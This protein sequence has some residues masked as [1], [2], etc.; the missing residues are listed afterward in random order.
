M[1]KLLLFIV[2]GLFYLT[3]NS[4]NYVPFPTDS[5]KWNCLLHAWGV[6]GQEYFINYRYTMDGD[7]LILG[8]QYKKIYFKDLED[9]INPR[10]Y[11]GGLRED[12][13]QQI[14]FFPYN[15]FLPSYT[16]YIFPDNTSEH[17]LYTFHNLNVGDTLPINTGYTK[18]WVVSIDSVLV[19]SNYRKRY[20]IHNTK[21]EFLPEYWIEGI[22]S[23]KDLLS[24]YTEEFEWWF[25]TMCFDDSI[26]YS[27]NPYAPDSCHY[28]STGIQTYGSNA[29]QIKVYPSPTSET[30]TIEM[31][32]I[33]KSSRVFIYNSN[34][35]LLVEKA[36]S[37]TKTNI[38]ITN[39]PKGLYFIK[40][41]AEQGMTVKKF[42]K[43]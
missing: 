5:A 20:E 8:K 27:V 35:K 42:V 25:Y 9:Q 2:F 37:E 4:Q 38:D 30:I 13:L 16:G 31:A 26:N 23:T 28:T 24:P 11:Y 22:G 33:E 39:L 21:M 40:L 3:M 7:T 15:T 36:I 19:G 29:L 14:F 32:S 1:K 17:L 18:I 6:P 41:T 34:G 12:S 43:E 10:V